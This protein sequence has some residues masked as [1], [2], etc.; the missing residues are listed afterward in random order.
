MGAKMLIFE[1]LGWAAAPAMGFNPGLVLEILIG[2]GEQKT[3][4]FSCVFTSIVRELVKKHTQ[5][6]PSVVSQPP[7]CCFSTYFL[8][9]AL[10]SVSSAICGRF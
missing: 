7:P 5:K 3:F 9:L 6:S 1:S 10:L 4:R 8:L 2:V